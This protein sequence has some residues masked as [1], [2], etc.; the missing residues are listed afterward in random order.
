MLAH[1]FCRKKAS[2]FDDAVAVALRSAKLFANYEQYAPAA[3][4]ACLCVDSWREKAQP[5]DETKLGVHASNFRFPQAISSVVRALLWFYLCIVADVRE[6]NGLM[7]PCAEQL[8]F[9]AACIR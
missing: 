7:S 5:I 9:L 8:K 1:A 3:E 6:I 2:A 4:A